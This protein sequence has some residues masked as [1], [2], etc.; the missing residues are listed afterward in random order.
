MDLIERYL[1]AV[2]WN[3]PAGKTEDI[4]AE[5]RDVIQSRIEDREEALDRALTRDE[6]SAL[7]KEF[8]H[9]IRVAGRYHGQRA[10][11][12][13]EVF[14]FYWFVLR[15]VLAIVAVIEA[16]QFAGR[17]IA[18]NAPLAQTISQGIASA[19]SSLLLNA[20]IVTLVFAVVERTGWLSEYLQKWKPESLPT[21]PR[22]EARPRKIWEPVFGIAIGIA[23]LGWWMGAYPVNWMPR[24]SDVAVHAAPI[25]STLYWPVAAL[26]AAKILQDAA[27]LLVPTWKPL[28][29]LLSIGCAAG[30]VAIAAILYQAGRL[31]TVNGVTANAEQVLHMQQGLDT[32]LGIAVPVIGALT[33]WQCGVELWRLYRERH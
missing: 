9:P 32:A 12:G 11:I 16:I 26:V 27:S 31:V 17:V 29:A 22:I 2:R 7:L 13:A 3:L 20:A 14:P 4:V 19:T 28:R 33:M 15:V 18:S 6:V 24:E 5:L 1:G 8:G 23:F 30:T 21:L 25:W 10:L